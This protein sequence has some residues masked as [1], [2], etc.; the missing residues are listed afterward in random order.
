MSE[1]DVDKTTLKT[2]EEYYRQA[3]TLKTTYQES[4]HMFEDPQVTL[5]LYNNGWQPEYSF[6]L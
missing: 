6:W 5:V 3:Y 4:N 1:E 2:S